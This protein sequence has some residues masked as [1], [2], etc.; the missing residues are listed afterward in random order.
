VRSRWCSAC[1]ARYWRIRSASCSID[2][3]R[4]T[5]SSRSAGAEVGAGEQGVDVV[6]GGG[7]G[8]G[9][10][11]APDR[12]DRAISHHKPPGKAKAPPKAC[13]A[14]LHKAVTVVAGKQAWQVQADAVDGW[15]EQPVQTRLI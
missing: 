5:V 12:R 4:A 15:H 8:V 1:S 2:P 14:T 3:H 7:V 10:L 13:G 6:E 11:A 9:V